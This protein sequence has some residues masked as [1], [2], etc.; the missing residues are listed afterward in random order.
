M[1]RF[2]RNNLKETKY[3]HITTHGISKENIYQDKR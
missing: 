1:P 3:V 2:I